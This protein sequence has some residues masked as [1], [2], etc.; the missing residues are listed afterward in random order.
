MGAD[1]GGGRDGGW[2]VPGGLGEGTEVRRGFIKF[3]GGQVSGVGL[4]K[5]RTDAE[6]RVSRWKAIKGCGGG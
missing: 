4:L 1:R 2:E 3:D 6:V 5:A